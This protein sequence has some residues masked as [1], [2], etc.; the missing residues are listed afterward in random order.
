MNVKKML[1]SLD[2]DNGFKKSPDLKKKIRT[3]RVW[4]M[5][6]HGQELA[7]SSPIGGFAV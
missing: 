7:G 2:D 5:R 6:I 4:R 1:N 3:R